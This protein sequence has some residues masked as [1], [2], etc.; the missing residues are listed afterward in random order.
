MTPIDSSLLTKSSDMVVVQMLYQILTISMICTEK[1][2][3]EDRRLSARVL[4]FLKY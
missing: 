2:T 1:P 3:E 4:R